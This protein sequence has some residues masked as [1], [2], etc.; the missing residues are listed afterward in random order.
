MHQPSGVRTNIQSIVPPRPCLLDVSVQ[1]NCAD[2]LWPFLSIEIGPCTETRRPGPYSRS[3]AS[4][5][6]R[7]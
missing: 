3:M 7:P 4:I 1:W 5:R 6:D 2:A